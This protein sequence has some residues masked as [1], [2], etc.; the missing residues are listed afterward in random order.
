MIVK[1]NKEREFTIKAREFLARKQ[2]DSA[3]IYY[4]AAIAQ[5]PDSAQLL[6]ERGKCNYELEK[7]ALALKDLNDAIDLNHNSSDL[8]ID[9]GLVYDVMGSDSKAITD[10][11]KAL[12]LR[13]NNLRALNAKG[14]FLLKRNELVQA[15]QDFSQ[16]LLVDSSN[17]DAL[18]N[19]ASVFQEMNLNDTAITVLDKALV[20]CPD[21]SR[22]YF[23]RGIANLILKNYEKAI[24]D[25]SVAI[26]L[27]PKNSMYVTERG[28]A[29][30][31]RKAFDSACSDWS[32]AHT[33][34]SQEAYL[35]MAK[36]CN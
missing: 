21:K 24:A 35:L 3:V 12:E 16:I 7:Y 8:Y 22:A 33:M 34:G 2:Y 29:Y 19:I 14:V 5:F 4:N 9:R 17:C 15:Y 6:Q 28:K 31:A 26:D 32:K 36:F 20:N 1:V 18:L 13:P 30:L 25:I 27:A 11:Y 23:K 10:F